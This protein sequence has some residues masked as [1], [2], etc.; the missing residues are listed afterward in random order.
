MTLLILA[1]Y[2]C[3]KIHQPQT[4]F[5]PCLIDKTTA[6]L[7][8]VPSQT[9]FDPV[10]CYHQEILSKIIIFFR[11]QFLKLLAHPGI[12]L[13]PNSVTQCR[14]K[15]TRVS[16]KTVSYRPTYLQLWAAGQLTCS[17]EKSTL[18]SRRVD[19]LPL[20]DSSRGC[21]GRSTATTATER[22]HCQKL[23]HNTL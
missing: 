2:S 14:K 20:D 21:D 11:K 16:D 9:R 15:P 4:I 6:H 17:F 7:Q 22:N 18:M 5:V 1:K 23:S 8:L 19:L 3:N 10:S 13:I 12:K